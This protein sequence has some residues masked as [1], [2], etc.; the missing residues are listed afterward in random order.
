MILS[1][2]SLK[3]AIL[4]ML[5]AFSSSACE[6]G[7]NT[8]Q[9]LEQSKTSPTQGTNIYRYLSAISDAYP[10]KEALT[11][12]CI[13]QHDFMLNLPEQTIKAAHD[14]RLPAYEEWS[15]VQEVESQKYKNKTVIV[16]PPSVNGIVMEKETKEI[17]IPYTVTE[18][19]QT[20]KRVSGTCIGTEYI[21]Q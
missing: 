6:K 5:L 20:I 8:T 19:I 9:L 7:K 15:E 16:Q 12:L 21:T 14:I 11:Q 17:Q 10:D 4:A 13:R 2:P 1:I 3:R 18:N